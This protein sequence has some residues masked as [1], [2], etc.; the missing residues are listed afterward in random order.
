MVMK[1]IALPLGALL[2]AGCVGP[3]PYVTPVEDHGSPATT[4]APTPG[5]VQTVETPPRGQRATGGG[6]AGVSAAA[7]AEPAD[8]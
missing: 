5:S 2:L 8:N 6:G 3:N 1:R 4:Q 7:G